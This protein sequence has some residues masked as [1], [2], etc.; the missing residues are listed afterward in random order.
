LTA[1][2]EQL[3][4]LA[5]KALTLASDAKTAPMVAL[6]AAARFQSLMRQLALED[7]AD[8]KVEADTRAPTV[9]PFPRHVG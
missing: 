7:P 4:A 3:L 9:R 5:V 6:A 8:G 2:E 1:T